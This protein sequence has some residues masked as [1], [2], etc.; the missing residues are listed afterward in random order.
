MTASA[1]PDF[2]VVIPARY[3]STRLPCKPLLSIGGKP[4]IAHVCERA[5][6]SRATEVV[7]ATDDE[8]IRRAV[9]A[10]GVHAVMTRSD[11]NSGTERIAE[12][13]DLCGWNPTDLIVNVQGDEPLIPPSAIQRVAAALAGQ[14]RAGMATLA[15]PID[16]YDEVSD[17][18]V[19]KVV[20]DRLGY[21]LYFS[22]APVPW[23]RERF[24]RGVL[25]PG[26]GMTWLRHVG[27]YAYTVGFLRRYIDWPVSP[28]ESVESLEQLRI[29]WNEGPIFVAC[30]TDAPPAGIDTRQDLERVNR[31]LSGD[32][33]VE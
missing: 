24:G 19:V 3:G 20:L 10:L 17:P 15:T 25:E 26:D 31:L 7:V 11:H 16:E 8:R 28:L 2:K 23:D 9:D 14:T 1:A 30:V 27:L 32:P 29:L 33:L 13:A 5:L 22:R 12:V 4:M 21:A 18:N 6:A